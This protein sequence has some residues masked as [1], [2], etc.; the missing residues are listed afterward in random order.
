VLRDG[1]PHLQAHFAAEAALRAMR[2][3]RLTGTTWGVT[4][5]AYDI[6]REPRN[7]EEKLAAADLVVTVCEY[8]ARHL[9]GPVP[10]GKPVEV[11]VMG[12]EPERFRRTTPYPGGRRVLAVGRL[13]EKKGFA[14]LIEAAAL[15]DGLDVEI[16]GH[17][18]LR[19]ELDALIA[20][21]GVGDRVTLHGARPHSFVRDRLEQADLLAMP[22]VVA[23]DGD[24]D[25]MP[26]VVK[27]AL[28]ME[29]PVVASDEVALP[30]MVHSGWGRLVPPGDPAALAEAMEE[31][32]ALPAEERA[33]MGKRGREFVAERFSLASQARRLAELVDRIAE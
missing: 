10:D 29:V 15:V 1:R 3:A 27:E 6:F 19:G 11:V 12:V 28:A 9:R 16:V 8:N 21:R 26:V 25:S 5:H 22:C 23:A 20:Q 31:L 24:R 30:E 2:L 18:P 7:L 4:A 13:V 33:A 32:L 14:H 17:G